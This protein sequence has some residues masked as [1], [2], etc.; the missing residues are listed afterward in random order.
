MAN[1]INKLE[2]EKEIIISK[3]NGDLTPNAVNMITAMV[4]EITR[5]LRYKY[6]DDKEDCMQGAI[7]D[8]LKYWDRFDPT[9]RNA[10]CFAYFSELIKN[11]LAKSWKEIHS[12]ST[13]NTISIQGNYGIYNI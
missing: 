2:L 8:V 3:K 6:E 13:S 11:G 7:L 10:N 1:Y 9:R 5:T 4:K 12:I